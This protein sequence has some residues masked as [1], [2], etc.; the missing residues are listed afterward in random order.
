MSFDPNIPLT[1]SEMKSAEMRDQFNGL[2]TLIDAIPPAPPET[3]PV[4]AASEAALFVAGDKAKLDSLSPGGPQSGDYTSRT[5]TLGSVYQP[6][7]AHDV[8]VIASYRL[9]YNAAADAYLE[10]RSDAGNPPTTVRA[11]AGASCADVNVKKVFGA[12]MFVV[13]QGSYYSLVDTS[14]G[15]AA[16]LP[17]DVQ[18][19]PINL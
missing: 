19:F 7:T 5:V 11:K 4:F 6:S 8:L 14:F 9:D 15:G 13:K 18:E 16:S 3:D 1:D 12:L 10:A 17:G 2:K